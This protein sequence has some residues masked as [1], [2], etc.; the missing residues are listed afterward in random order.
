MMQDG[1]RGEGIVIKNYGFSNRYGRQTW[2]KIVTSEFKEKHVKEQGPTEIQGKQMVEELIA[3]EFVTQALCEKVRAKIE[4]EKGDWSSRYIGELLGTVF[5]DVV[6]EE[7]WQFIK[8]H[9]FPTIN[10]KTLRTFVNAEVK[11]KLPEVF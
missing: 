6:R 11:Q 4:T 1:H 9:K 3:Q 8:K 2:A 10:Y 5:Y 7:S